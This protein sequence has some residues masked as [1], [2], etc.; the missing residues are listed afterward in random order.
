MH[1]ERELFDLMRR[2]DVVKSATR[3]LVYFQLLDKQDLSFSHF[4]KSC[5]NNNL[6][7][8][9]T[10]W[11]K[12]YGKPKSSDVHW[13]KLLHLKD[14]EEAKEEFR[15]EL[16]LHINMNQQELRNYAKNIYELRNNLFA[17]TSIQTKKYHI[18]QM[19]I[20]IEALLFYYDK[21]K[22]RLN[23]TGV[24]HSE[25]LCLKLWIENMN[26]DVSPLIE[27]ILSESASFG[28]NT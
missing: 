15:Q 8:A 19:R 26:K 7:H 11:Y 4:W 28:E 22:E 9:C 13:Q 25:P 2:V 16:F 21:L 6:E 18:P 24:I 17:H 14:V 23:E 27:H 12:C 10:A 5:K 3:S 1:D 20:A